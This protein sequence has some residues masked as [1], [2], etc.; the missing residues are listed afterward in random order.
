[1]PC[2]QSVHWE[3]IR[4]DLRGEYGQYVRGPKDPGPF[5]GAEFISYVSIAHS[6]K[7]RLSLECIDCSLIHVSIVG[8]CVTRSFTETRE[9]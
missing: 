3:G 2:L 7:C 9:F 8:E 1:M 6:T 4:E 5:S